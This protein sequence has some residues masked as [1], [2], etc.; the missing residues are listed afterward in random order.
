MYHRDFDIA[1]IMF[2]SVP[3]GAGQT[4]EQSTIG[5]QWHLATSLPAANKSSSVS[6][7][8]SICDDTMDA[9]RWFHLLPHHSNIRVALHSS[10]KCINTG[11]RCPSRMRV[12][13]MVSYFQHLAREQAGI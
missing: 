6:P 7:C 2:G 4:Y 11:P 10:V 12:H 1:G 13:S 8:T 5:S 3:V 9:P